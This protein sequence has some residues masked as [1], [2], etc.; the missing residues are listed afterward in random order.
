MRGSPDAAHL[1]QHLTWRRTTEREP[2]LPAAGSGRPGGSILEDETVIVAMFRACIREER[3]EEY[4]RKAEEMAEIARRMPGF[5]AYKAYRSPDGEVYFQ[6]G[7][8]DPSMQ[9]GFASMVTVAGT[10]NT[11]IVDNNITLK[12]N[13]ATT[14]IPSLTIFPAPTLSGIK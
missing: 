2:G 5:I 9:S 3:E 12:L 14:P 10:G 1:S 13:N 11:V 6:A 8:G 4:Y 7:M